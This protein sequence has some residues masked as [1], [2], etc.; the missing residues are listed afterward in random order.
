VTLAVRGTC[1]FDYSRLQCE[2]QTT[3][4]DAAILDGASLQGRGR[5]VSAY[6]QP[7]VGAHVSCCNRCS[8]SIVT[9]KQAVRSRTTRCR[10]RPP[11]DP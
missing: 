11:C 5:A 8:V 7:L 2:R 10:G 1:G 3:R 6:R 9:R 4:I